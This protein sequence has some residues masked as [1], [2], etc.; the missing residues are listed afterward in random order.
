MPSTSLPGRI[1][2][3]LKRSSQWIIF[4]IA[5]TGAGLTAEESEKIFERFY[6]ASRSR[7]SGGAGL[8]LAI[9]RE[10]FNN[11]VFI[12]TNFF[13]HIELYYPISFY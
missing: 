8:G 11:P 6:K 3:Q 13:I 12:N 9:A 7:G 10:R 1:V 4:S 5:D 2:L